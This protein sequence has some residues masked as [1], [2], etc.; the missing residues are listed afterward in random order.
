MSASP[1]RPENGFVELD[2]TEC[3][4]LLREEGVGILGTLVGDE[5]EQRPVN[6]VVHRSRIIVRTDR[7]VLFEA[8]RR[9]ESA[10]LAV[11]SLDPEARTAWSVIAKGTLEPADA[12]LAGAQLFSWAHDGKDERIQLS[13]ETLS[14]RRLVARDHAD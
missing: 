2:E 3:K 12:S 4:Q 9:G 1:E 6:Y 7:G 5:V 13:I 11:M 8:A 14:G 10:S